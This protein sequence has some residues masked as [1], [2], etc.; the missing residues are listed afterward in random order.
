MSND[1]PNFRLFAGTLEE[2]IAKYGDPA[3]DDR[4]LLQ[5]QR[6]QFES[7]VAMEK[8]FREVLIRSR[9]GVLVY[10]GFVRKIC[11]QN[12]NILTARPFFRER[13]GVCLGPIT[14]ALKKRHLPSLYLYHF[15]YNFIAFVVGLRSWPPAGRIN[16]LARSIRRL[17]KEIIETNMPLAISEAR[18]FWSKAPLKTQDTRFTFMDFVQIAADGLTSAVDKFVLPTPQELDEDLGKISI[19]RSVAIQRMTGNFIEM[20]G[21]TSIHFFPPD[22]RKLYRANKHLKEHQGAID[23]D[24]LAQ[25]VNADLGPKGPQTTARELADLMGAASGHTSAD[26]NEDADGI[27]DSIVDRASAAADWQ[28]DV[29]FERAEVS[30]LLHNSI[31][32]LDLVERKLLRMRGIGSD[33]I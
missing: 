25:Q 4:A 3:A 32:L 18:R 29:R 27:H 5:K 17:R 13:Q 2:V 16:E 28:P 33:S 21:E 1:D 23:F 19:W 9:Q 24:R 12:G 15:N 8:E 30:G 6:Q 31:L 14:K 26:S 7:L 10:R 22:K 11:D 20:F